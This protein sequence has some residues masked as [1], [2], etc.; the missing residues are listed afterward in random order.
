MILI[1]EF[2]Q[3]GQRIKC[4]SLNPRSMLNRY[5]ESAENMMSICYHL[6]GMTGGGTVDE[7]LIFYGDCG[8]K[9]IKKR[10]TP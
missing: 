3:T 6:S 8:R 5:V 10:W 1:P 2:Q 9:H 7:G 4:D